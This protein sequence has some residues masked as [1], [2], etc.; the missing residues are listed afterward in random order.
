MRRVRVRWTRRRFVR[1]ALAATTAGIGAGLGACSRRA[2][3][4]AARALRVG[5][6]TPATGA[7]AAFSAAD[8]YVL[9]GVRASLRR[10]VGRGALV[11]PVEILARDSQSNPNRAAEVTSEL[12]DKNRV[13]L[14][15]AASTADTVNPVADICEANEV[16]CLTTDTPWQ[17]YFFGR[18]GNP[19]A[20]FQWT[21]H[22]FWGVDAL[23]EVYLDIWDRL[24]TNRVVGALWPNDAEGNAFAD[25]VHG[26]PPAMRARGYRLVDLGRFQPHTD[27]FSAQVRAF[28]TA[29]V[30]ILTGVL[31]PPS[32]Q[33]FWTQAAQQEFRPRI[34]TVA[35]ALLFPAAVAGLGERGFGLSTEV[36]WS[37][38][39]PFRSSLDGRSASEFAADYTRATG[40]PWT[41]P[42]GFRHALFEV[43]ADV[44]RRSADIDD[45]GAIRN[46]IAATDLATLVGPVRMAGGPVPNVATTLL[47]GGQWQ[48]GS[49]AA[50]EL[51]IVDDQRASVIPVT[52]DLQELPG[53][54]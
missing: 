8:D 29:G 53:G 46:A 35:K 25:P 4:G 32:F 52:A 51:Q 11:H 24:T 45:P 42:M 26:F 31:T 28:K 50:P 44:L 27:D 41:Q 18:D 7:L 20:P 22:F 54:R 6:V 10:G 37:P 30:Q 14:V 38:H 15:L 5:Y 3:G 49:G 48:R 13:D 9:A 39:H 19:R 16:P 2:T 17:P 40:R 36:W 33:T 1:A 23:F 43:A 47:V 34:A 21:Y 12:I